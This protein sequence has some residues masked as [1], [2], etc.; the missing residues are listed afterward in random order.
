[1]LLKNIEPTIWP[2][3]APT[4]SPMPVSAAKVP[5]RLIGTRSGMIA[6][7]GPCAKLKQT[8]TSVQAMMKP[9]S[10]FANARPTSESAPAS[11]PIT[12][13]GRTAAEA[14]PRAVGDLPGDR[15]GDHRGE[16]ADR[17]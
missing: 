11:A 8:C 9:T 3:I 10:E 14:R 1:M 5:R 7:S 16:G 12:I 2:P 6:D 17:R 15:L 13:H 4:M